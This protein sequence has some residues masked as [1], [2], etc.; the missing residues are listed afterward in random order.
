MSRGHQVGRE[1]DAVEAQAQRLD[2]RRDQQRL[3]QPR[4]ADQQRV[5]RAEQ[6]DQQLLDHRLLPDDHLAQF[7]CACCD[8]ACW[9]FSTAAISSAARSVACGLTI[10]IFGFSSAAMGC[11][12]CPVI[13][14]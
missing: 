11:I 13:H 3:G 4:H 7:G 8:S 1:L 2:E 5:A 12:S 10:V 14:A 9:S 6:R